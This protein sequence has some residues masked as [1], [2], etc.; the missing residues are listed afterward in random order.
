MGIEGHFTE[1]LFLF[2][3]QSQK[4]FRTS[5]Y[6]VGQ[7]RATSKIVELQPSVLRDSWR[8]QFFRLK[9][10]IGKHKCCLQLLA[11]LILAFSVKKTATQV[12]WTRKEW[13]IGKGGSFPATESVQVDG[14][15]SG[16]VYLGSLHLLRCWRSLVER[17][18]LLSRCSDSMRGC[19]GEAA[20]Q[21]NQ[22]CHSARRN[23]SSGL[24]SATILFDYWVFGEDLLVLLDFSL[25]FC[26]MKG[27]TNVLQGSS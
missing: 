21:W 5:S 22:H 7:R 17:R 3:F 12:T 24:S 1:A 25:Y 2:S 23:Q 15:Q 10:I 14:C 27:W 20:V 4:L 11:G 26:K 6:Y 19:Q 18:A 8:N 13:I 16:L 9:K